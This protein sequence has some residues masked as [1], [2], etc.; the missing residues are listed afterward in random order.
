MCSNPPDFVAVLISDCIQ[1]GIT[2]PEEIAESIAGQYIVDDCKNDI[3]S[4]M[5]ATTVSEQE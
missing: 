2:D 4:L 3:L 5:D 1:R